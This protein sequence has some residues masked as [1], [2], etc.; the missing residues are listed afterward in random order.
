MGAR[1]ERGEAWR[2]GRPHHSD[3]APVQ[4]LGRRRD[5][6]GLRTSLYRQVGATL[7]ATARG[8]NGHRRHLI[9]GAGSD[10][11]RHHTLLRHGQRRGPPSLPQASPCWPSAGRSPAPPPGHGVDID[12]LTRGAGFGYIGSTVTSLIY[13]SFTFIL[14]AIEASIMSTALEMAPRPAALGRLCRLD[15]SGD[16]TGHTTAS[17]GSAASRS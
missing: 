3:T 15:A 6:R 14:F 9:S 7:V 13:A 11:R 10:R 8:A 1:Q 2:R 4:P 12:L 16:P 5:P 17:P